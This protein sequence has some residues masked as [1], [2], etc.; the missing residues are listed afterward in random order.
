MHLYVAARKRF[1]PAL[2][3][4]P[5]HRQQKTPCLVESAPLLA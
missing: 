1:Q 4:V 2:T 5:E 3:R